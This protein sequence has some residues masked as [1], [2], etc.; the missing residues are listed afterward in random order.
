M[1]NKGPCIFI[2]HG[3]LDNYVDFI[4]DPGL[5]T[6]GK[7]GG[8]QVSIGGSFKLKSWLEVRNVQLVLKL[9]LNNG[10]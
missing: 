2:L 4:A 5:K 1:L 9:H 3:N 10:S 7:S 6:Q 8:S